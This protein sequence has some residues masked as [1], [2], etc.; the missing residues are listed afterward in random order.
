M[1]KAKA[2]RKWHAARRRWWARQPLTI[3]ITMDAEAL[4]LALFGVSLAA[5]AAADAMRGFGDAIQAA[6]A[7]DG[8]CVRV[9][10]GGF[11]ALPPGDTLDEAA[12]IDVDAWGR[13]QVATERVHLLEGARGGGKRYQLTGGK[14][15]A[16][17]RD[18][19]QELG[20]VT[21]GEFVVQGRRMPPHGIGCT[22]VVK[23]VVKTGSDGQRHQVDVPG[24]PCDWCERRRRS[25]SPLLCEC[26]GGPTCG[27]CRGHGVP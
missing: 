2:A 24:P 10:A 21:S 26:D 23:R 27:Y 5:R 20:T 9:P 8:E 11:L 16:R 13:M 7:I 3:T 19:M 17:S 25:W 1:L 6:G 4:A 12:S 22:C 14:L 18:G 15:Y